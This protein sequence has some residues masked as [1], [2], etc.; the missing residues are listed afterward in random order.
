[1]EL[2]QRWEQ[3]SGQ[4]HWE[5][6]GAEQ[7]LA[8]Y[9]ICYCFSEALKKIFSSGKH[10]HDHLEAWGKGKSSHYP[11]QKI[12]KDVKQAIALQPS[13]LQVSSAVTCP[14]LSHML[15][16]SQQWN[17]G[18]GPDAFALIPL[19]PLSHLSHLPVSASAPE[20]PLCFSPCTKPP[21][22]RRTEECIPAM[23]GL[24]ILSL[25]G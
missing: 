25:L 15:T 13:I 6:W 2:S 5:V 21:Q 14:F 24:C 20:L 12:S 7:P 3:H 11:S 23:L 16:H 8:N 10:K 1:M 18:D 17:S 22:K 19:L 4:T 9:A